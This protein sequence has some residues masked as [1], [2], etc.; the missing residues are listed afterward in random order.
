[1]RIR[2]L[3]FKKVS[4]IEYKVGREYEVATDLGNEL[5]A[6]NSAVCLDKPEE[7]SLKIKLENKAIEKVEEDKEVEEK[8][9]PK[10]EIEEKK[11]TKRK[12]TKRKTKK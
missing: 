7:K 5:V 4:G 8:E 10:E 11:E 1:M 3:K 2:V 12:T 9:E 6:A